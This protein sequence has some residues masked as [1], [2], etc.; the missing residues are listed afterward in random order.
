MMIY[1]EKKTRFYGVTVEKTGE[2]RKLSLYLGEKISLWKKGGGQNI[3][4]FDN[5]HPCSL[6]HSWS[7]AD[8][9]WTKIGDVVGAAGG[10]ESTSGKK[11][12]QAKK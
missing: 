12:Y 1:S 9:K 2:K 6:V 3:N 7:M 5:I 10:S 4:Y 8:Q 11:L